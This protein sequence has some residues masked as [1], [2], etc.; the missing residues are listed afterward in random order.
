MENSRRVGR[1]GVLSRSL[2][3][4]KFLRA[5]MTKQLTLYYYY[6]YYYYYYL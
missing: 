6:Y 1:K 5:Q 2:K 4:C 3:A